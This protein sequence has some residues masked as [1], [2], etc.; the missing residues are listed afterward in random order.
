MVLRHPNIWLAALFALVLA[1]LATIDAASPPSAA[2][3]AC[4]KWGEEMPDQLAPKEARKA[5]VCLLNVE[6]QKAGE[7]TLDNDKKL[8]KAAQHHTDVMDGSGCFDHECPGEAGL[9]QRLSIVDYLTNGLTRWMY[10]EN[11]AWGSGKLGTPKE[12]VKAWMNS[13]PHRTTLLTNSF[14]DVGIGFRD[15]TPS[16]ARAQGGIYTAD[17]GLRVG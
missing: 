9:D 1:L 7:H 15:G 12:I 10:G 14:D 5:I 13:P 8:Q 6:R 11:I 2:A 17:F 16:N 3:S 4:S